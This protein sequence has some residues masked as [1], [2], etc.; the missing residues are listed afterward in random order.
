[1]TDK[2]CHLYFV[3]HGETTWNAQGLLQGH[4]DIELNDTGI[5]QAKAL[6]EILS[7]VSFDAAFSSD[8]LR[9]KKT[10]DIILEDNRIPLILATQLRERFAG[11]FE[12]RPVK[13]L[14]EWIKQSKSEKAFTHQEHL[15]HRWHPE[16]ETSSEVYQ[17]VKSF[18]D[19]RY[20]SH[21]GKNI[22]VVSHGGVI[23]SFLDHLKYEPGYKWVVSN[24]GYICLQICDGE[25]FIKD[26]HGIVFKS[27]TNEV[28]HA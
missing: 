11:P 4:S 28:A 12:G 25:V 24:C 9:A 20:A 27:Y 6:K 10:A 22:L 15:S 19:E 7:D 1:M 17:R 2:G 21:V 5:S 18:L 16:L 14:E 8:L 23:R 26:S 3:R 13:D